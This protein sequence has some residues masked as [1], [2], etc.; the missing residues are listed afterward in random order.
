MKAPKIN[1]GKLASIEVEQKVIEEL[2]DSS[3]MDEDRSITI[4]FENV[5][6][7]LELLKEEYPEKKEMIEFLDKVV[8]GLDDYGDEELIQ[9]YSM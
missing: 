5:V 2:R 4:M 1:L 7:H 8:E 6:E 3:A 9:F